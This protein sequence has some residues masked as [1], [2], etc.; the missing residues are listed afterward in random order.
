[1]DLELSLNIWN[2][3]RPHLI[4]DGIVREAADDFVHVLIENGADA[5]EI[6]EY[7]IDSAL[8]SA[9]LDYAELEVDE[10]DEDDYDELNFD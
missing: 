8:K 9:L 3:L 2:T 6:A 1:M 7:A 4:G 5:E 10:E